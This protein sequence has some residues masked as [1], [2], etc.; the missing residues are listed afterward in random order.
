MEQ[1]YYK[2]VNQ[3]NKATY[4]SDVDEE[5]MSQRLGELSDKFIGE[6]SEDLFDAASSRKPKASRSVKPSLDYSSIIELV[7]QGKVFT[8]F[9]YYS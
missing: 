7:K 2:Y 1:Y 3:E 9:N 8:Y 5:R 6:G 4:F